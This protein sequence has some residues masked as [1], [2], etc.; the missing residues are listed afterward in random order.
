[1]SKNA[2]FIKN[3]V[4]GISKGEVK[5]F[6]DQTFKRLKKDKFV[7]EATEEELKEYNEFLKNRNTASNYAEIKKAAN[8]SEE[9]E[10]CGKSSEK[11]EE[12]GDD[13]TETKK[14]HVLSQ[15]DIDANELAAEGF[16]VGDEV[17]INEE[18]ELLVDEDGKLIGKLGNV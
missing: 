13:V 14:Y 18:E 11:C 4:S 9:C 5:T 2:K 16:E 15:E 1:M 10:E 8:T 7:V 17:E 12:C 3:H 6:D